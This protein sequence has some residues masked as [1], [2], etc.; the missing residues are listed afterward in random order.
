MCQ[1]YFGGKLYISC[2]GMK[3][4]VEIIKGSKMNI[5]VSD[6]IGKVVMTQNINVIAGNNPI[7]MNFATLGAGTYNIKVINAD[8]EVKTTRFVKY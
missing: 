2:K 1:I 5:A 6:M 3:S 7:T 8:N 4:I